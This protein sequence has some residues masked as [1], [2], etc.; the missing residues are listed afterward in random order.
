M[1]LVKIM[2]PVT[3]GARDAQAL[4][5][6]LAAAR[7]F[8]AHLTALFVRA[9]PRE[10]IPFGELPLS[11]DFVQDLIETTAGVENAAAAA[12]RSALAAMAGGPGAPVGVSYEEITGY[13]PQV[14]ARAAR[15]CDLVVFPPLRAKDAHDMPDAFAR[16]LVR[17]ACP[18]LL[19]PERPPETLG[20]R[21]AIGWD[22]G[23][24][25]ARALVGAIPF[26]AKAEKIE[27]LSVRDGDVPSPG[28]EEAIHYLALHGLSATGRTLKRAGRKVAETLLEAA[29]GE[30]FDMLVT[31]G[32]G[33]GRLT[34][35]VFGGVTEHVVSHASLPVFMV[36]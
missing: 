26:L 4:A 28:E 10:A 8:G 9:D 24:A 33:R 27:L 25:C 22:D 21:I 16:V 13:L 2:V 30:G 29:A 20:R 34:E 19:S 36:H 14:L 11:P 17:T 3:G 1:S 18:V 5:T 35:A 15:L 31:G 23:V 7:L 32:Y 6:A 12:A